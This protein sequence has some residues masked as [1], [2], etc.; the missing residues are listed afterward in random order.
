MTP[1]LHAR[2]SAARW[3]GDPDSYMALHEWF[4]ATKTLTGNWTH[5]AMR[6][7]AFGIQEAIGVFGHTIT[8][9]LGQQI[10]TKVLAEQHVMEDCGF[11]PTVQDW[12]RPLASLPVDW[13]LKVGKI[14]TQPLEV[15]PR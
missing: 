14:T 12:L 2:S 7:H 15:A 9:S 11:I 3:G 4:D 8:N 13:M 6:H 10:P 1:V 5:R